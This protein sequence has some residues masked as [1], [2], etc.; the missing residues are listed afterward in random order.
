MHTQFSYF[1]TCLNASRPTSK[2]LI[3]Q[4]GKK[5]QKLKR[6]TEETK[7]ALPPFQQTTLMSV[8]F[9]LIHKVLNDLQ[10]TRRH[11]SFMKKT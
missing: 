3:A 1:L 5:T 6:D 2:G 11:F 4:R 10:V 7:T 8:K 9:L